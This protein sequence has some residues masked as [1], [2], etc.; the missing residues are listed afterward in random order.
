MCNVKLQLCTKGLAWSMGE[1]TSKACFLF[2]IMNSRNRVFNLYFLISTC[3]TVLYCISISNHIWLTPTMQGPG[4]WYVSGLFGVAWDVTP[5]HCTIKKN[6]PELV[7]FNVKKTLKFAGNSKAEPSTFSMG[8]NNF[9]W[10]FYLAIFMGECSGPVVDCLTRDREV[11]GSSLIGRRL[12]RV[13]GQDTIIL[14]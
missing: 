3:H 6:P 11:A 1:S 8:K 7:G 14:A 13:L 5:D 10:N 9:L 12:C 2:P 4:E